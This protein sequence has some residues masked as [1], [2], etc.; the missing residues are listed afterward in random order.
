MEEESVKDAHRLLW[1][2]K[3]RGKTLV[4]FRVVLSAA[5]ARCFLPSI[6]SLLA[7]FLVLLGPGIQL[8][9]L[10]IIWLDTDPC[11]V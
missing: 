6:L 9:F 1:R 8:K 4:R 7:H 2:A 10:Q 5:V 3:Y 11:A